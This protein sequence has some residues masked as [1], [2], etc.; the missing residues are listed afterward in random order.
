MSIGLGA[1]T[2]GELDMKAKLYRNHSAPASPLDY[3][4]E[5]QPRQEVQQP[6]SADTSSDDVF[7]VTGQSIE[8]DEILD[9][10]KELVEK[11]SQDDDSEM[12]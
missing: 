9:S 11:V 4:Q 3:K 12:S 1:L 5:V 10:N 6:D 7:N 8:T 2:E